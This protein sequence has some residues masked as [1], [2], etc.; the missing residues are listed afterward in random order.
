MPSEVLAT[1]S[2]HCETST[3]AI[4]NSDTVDANSNRA[5]A[6]ATGLDSSMIGVSY[7]NPLSEWWNSLFEKS[8]HAEKHM[9]ESCSNGNDVKSE[10]VWRKLS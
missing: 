6:I 7:S 10:P 3:N 2:Q 8:P 4:T 9:K 5:D 1:L